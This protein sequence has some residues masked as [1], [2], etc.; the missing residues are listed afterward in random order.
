M[1]CALFHSILQLDEISLYASGLA[2]LEQNLFTLES[3]KTFD[4]R[5]GG[6]DDG[7]GAGGGDEESSA[8]D[9]VMLKTREPLKWYFNQLDHSV[10]LSFTSNFHFALVGHLIKGNHFFIIFLD[11]NSL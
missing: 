8:L 6:A 5:G 1:T 2:L 3:Q 7:D 9:V 10:G 4:A 11:K